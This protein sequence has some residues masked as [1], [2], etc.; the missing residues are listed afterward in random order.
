LFRKE[1]MVGR[2]IE[3]DWSIVPYGTIQGLF[4]DISIRQLTDF[5]YG[6]FNFN[7]KYQINI[8]YYFILINYVVI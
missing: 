1:L 2:N 7:L 3:I 6:K 4:I 5:P 8:R